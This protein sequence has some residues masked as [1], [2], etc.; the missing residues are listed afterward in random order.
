[1]LFDV[2]DDGLTARAKI[3]SFSLGPVK[4]QEANMDL[5]LTRS[6]QYFKLTGRSDLGFA[7]ADIQM[8]KNL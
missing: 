3:D 7:N 6:E 8:N 4:L 2:G 1:M 5:T